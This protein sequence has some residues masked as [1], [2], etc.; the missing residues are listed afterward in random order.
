MRLGLLKNMGLAAALA[1]LSACTPPY[2]EKAHLSVAKDYYRSCGWSADCRAAADALPMDQ[3]YAV[4]LYGRSFHPW[5]SAAGHIA[6]RGEAAVPLLREKL[7][8]ARDGGEISSLFEIFTAM[9]DLKSFDV[10]SD[11][12]LVSLI[13]DAAHRVD[14]PG[15]FLRDE[16]DEL[17]T[18][19][20]R[21]FSPVVVGRKWLHGHAKDYDVKFA[22]SHCRDCDFRA[23]KEGIETLPIDKLYALYR[24]GWEDFHPARNIEPVLAARGAAAIPFVKT[25]LAEASDSLMLMNLLSLLELMRDSGSYQPQRDPELLALVDAAVARV[26]DYNDSNREAAKRLR[27]GTQHPLAKLRAG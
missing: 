20:R 3:L 6:R 27:N 16:A 21:P 26:K 15:Y 23:W 12:S 2:V 10:R 25:K 8:A 13:Q 14:D 4:H 11:P 24:N 5:R 19:E 22:V 7:A 1:A 18:G 9:Q 17:E